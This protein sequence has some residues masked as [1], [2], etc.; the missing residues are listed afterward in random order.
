MSTNGG[1]DRVRDPLSTVDDRRNH[2]RS[3]RKRVSVLILFEMSD[4]QVNCHV[5]DKCK[6]MVSR[7]EPRRER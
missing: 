2:Q 7:F 3:W 6:P 1:N 4:E 5:F